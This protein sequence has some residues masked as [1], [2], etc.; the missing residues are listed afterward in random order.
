MGFYAYLKV[1]YSLI[2]N[3]KH[4]IVIEVIIIGQRL[5]KVKQTLL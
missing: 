2:V 5:N 4:G 1:P 3:T